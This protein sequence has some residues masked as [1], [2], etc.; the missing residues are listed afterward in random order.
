MQ[1]V[2]GLSLCWHFGTDTTSKM[3]LTSF[4]AAAAAVVCLVAHGILQSYGW[5]WMQ[6]MRVRMKTLVKNLN[7]PVTQPERG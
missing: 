7:A 4:F 2:G 5:V 3:R 6:M 1:L